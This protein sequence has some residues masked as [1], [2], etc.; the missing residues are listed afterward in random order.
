MK[1]FGEGFAWGG[2]G[3]EGNYIETYSTKVACK[4]NSNLG[5]SLGLWS[6]CQNF[7]DGEPF[8]KYYLT[9][10]SKIVVAFKFKKQ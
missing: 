8:Q 6:A 5:Y 10:Q 7:D 4:C 9:D 2:L 3:I 1:C